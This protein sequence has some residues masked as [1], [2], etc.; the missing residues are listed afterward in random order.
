[1][2]LHKKGKATTDPTGFR[3]VCLTSTLG[4]LVTTALREVISDHMGT[5]ELWSKGQKGF[6][7]RVSGCKEHHAMLDYFIGHVEYT[8]GLSPFTLVMTD[9][10]NAFGTVRH[11]LIDYALARYRL[12]PW[13]ANRIKSLNQQ[14]YW[15]FSADSDPV[16]Q[17]VGVFQGDPMS[18]VLFQVALNVLLEGLDERLN[19]PGNGIPFLSRGERTLLHAAHNEIPLPRATGDDTEGLRINHLTFA[20][21]INLFATTPEKAQNLLDHFGTMLLWAQTLKG[22]GDKFNSVTFGY[23]KAILPEPTT[24]ALVSRSSLTHAPF[25]EATTPPLMFNGSVLPTL[26][27]KGPFRL[28]GKWFS[29]G[30][31][32]AQDVIEPVVLARAKELIKRLDDHESPGHLKV[33][34]MALGFDSFMRWH[35]EVNKV[36]K[37]W[38]KDQLL[39]LITRH[40]RKWTGLNQSANHATFFL[41]SSLFGLGLTHPE[42]LYHTARVQQLHGLLESEDERVV[43][44]TWL[45]AI[46]ESP[47]EW[48]PHRV[49]KALLEK[50]QGGQAA[51]APGPFRKSLRRELAL[52]H[53]GD[54]QEQLLESL[55]K[56]KIAGRLVAQSP[57][58]GHPEWLGAL[59]NLPLAVARFGM[60]SLQEHNPTNARLSQWN[61]TRVSAH[62][63]RCKNKGRRVEQTLTHVLTECCILGGADSHDEKKNRVT[64]RHNDVLRSIIRSIKSCDTV[65]SLQVYS[66]LPGFPLPPSSLF[67][68][69]SALKPDIVVVSDTKIVIGELTSCM[70]WNMTAQHNR[71]TEKYVNL[72]TNIKTANPGK[73]V[74]LIAFEVSVRGVVT[75]HLTEFL[76][77]LG[78]PKVQ[79]KKAR[80]TASAAA[81]KASHRMFTHRNDE[82]W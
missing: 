44:L 79:I 3:P 40:L 66:D 1:V 50:I 12:P 45:D 28:L 68:A 55:K 32:P 70:E 47:R 10:A 36:S 37:K 9:L 14:L 58:D 71:K 8:K 53:R 21:D 31:G 23:G 6:L 43:H 41:P 42:H 74:A 64:K 15:Q 4:K 82:A 80:L 22:R 18:P 24:H 56:L 59:W 11:S 2:F 61:P 27:G 39:S 34:M 65:K 38:L 19:T 29:T 51:A 35:L 67:H 73:S 60:Q 52:V 7:P 81:L 49:H 5:H 33:A 26:H 25:T 20:D 72:T 48:S 16:R 77:E 17:E 54:H 30:R 62:C 75:D 46:R 76:K 57:E 78:L 63:T 69:G 13:L